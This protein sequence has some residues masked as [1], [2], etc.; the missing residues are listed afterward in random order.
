M[1]LLISDANI[2]IDM[3]EGQLIDHMFSLPF[4]FSTPDI[5]FYE[6]LEQHHNYLLDIGLQTIELNSETLQYVQKISGKYPKTSGNDRFALA[7]ARQ[8]ECPLLTGDRD[9][10]VAANI[11]SIDVKGTIWIVNQMVMNCLITVEKARQAYKKMEEAGR[12]LPW[13]IAEQELIEIQ[14]GQN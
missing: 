11:E 7:L 2:L 6:E 8:E 4:Q 13:D 14:N 3:E 10:R 9:L 5:L 1:Q 12:R